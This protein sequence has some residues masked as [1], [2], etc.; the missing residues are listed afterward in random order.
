MLHQ[1]TL[2]WG[3]VPPHQGPRVDR[4]PVGLWVSLALQG[5]RMTYTSALYLKECDDVSSTAHVSINW[6]R[7][8]ATDSS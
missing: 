8:L 6:Q 5:S 4:M 7:K 1:Q 3:A 2:Y